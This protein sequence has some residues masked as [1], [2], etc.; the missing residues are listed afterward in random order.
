M[1]RLANLLNPEN[2]VSQKSQRPTGRSNEGIQEK[3]PDGE[4][5]FMGVQVSKFPCPYCDESFDYKMELS[6]HINKWHPGKTAP[7]QPFKPNTVN[8]HLTGSH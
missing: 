5:S 1:D 6:M 4:V 7:V 2:R 8:S 3:S